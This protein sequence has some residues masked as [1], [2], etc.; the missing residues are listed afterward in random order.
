MTDELADL[1]LLAG[2]VL[3]QAATADRF[4]DTLDEWLGDLSAAEHDAIK[5]ERR[6]RREASQ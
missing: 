2:I 4:G 1:R 6:R 5:R 3:R